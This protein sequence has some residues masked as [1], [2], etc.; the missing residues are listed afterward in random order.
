MQQTWDVVVVGLGAMGS[1]ALYQSSL[2]AGRV[3]GID[4]FSP[5]H[6]RGSSHGDTRITRQAIGEG[7]EF[8]PLALR[9]REIWR[10]LERESGTK[11]YIENGVLVFGR[12]GKSR[13]DHGVAD[14]L[15]GTRRAAEEFG[16]AHEVLD[17]QALR[18]RF[19]QFRYSGDEVGYYEPG[20]G[21]LRPEQ[22]IAANLG[23]AQ[24]NGA[25]LLLDC[26][27]SS[28]APSASGD[29]VV[30]HCDGRTLHA[31]SVIVAAGAW[32]TRFLPANVAGKLR[33]CRQVLHWFPLAGDPTPFAPECC[34][35]FIRLSDADNTM[36]YGFP[37]VDGPGGGVK[38]ALEQLETC[39]EPDQLERAVSVAE[40]A[41]SWRMAAQFLPL[42]A[43]PVRQL[44]CLYTLTPDFGFI[45]DRHPRYPQL[46]FAS[47]CS[48]HGF[49]HSAA[50][51]EL[52]AELAVEGRS[53]LDISAFSLARYTD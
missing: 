47:A 33:V 51:G 34:P 35:V 31:A 15:A 38:V 9:S 53:T 43:Q 29:G 14:F 19:P 37:A 12:E 46:V 23:C 16:I 36:V 18:Q 50:I 52:L 25:E 21:Y 10:S 27:V 42:L 11:V 49:K 48:G 22:C 24:R 40:T 6:D 4:R 28:L 1:A 45:I 2:R 30:V 3:L 41:S 26:T 8:V 44:T 13:C 20:G 39:C 17:Q 7:R 32:N 5:P